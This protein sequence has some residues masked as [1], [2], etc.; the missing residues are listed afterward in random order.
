MRKNIPLYFT[1]CN[2]V[3]Q[4]SQPK[5]DWAKHVTDYSAFDFG[6]FVT[7][8]TEAFFLLVV[9]NNFDHW[10]GLYMHRKEIKEIKTMYGKGADHD[11]HMK[12]FHQEKN[13]AESLYTSGHKTRR[14]AG[15]TDAGVIWYNDLYTAVAADRTASNNEAF[16][17]H[18]VQYFM[19][20][21]QSIQTVKNH[22][23]ESNKKLPAK[24]KMRFRGQGA[25][26]ALK[27]IQ[28]PSSPAPM[29]NTDT[30]LLQPPE[31]QK[32]AA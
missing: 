25:R 2:T 23:D 13:I 31:Q 10:N 5:K 26:K 11:K 6:E 29:D 18:I 1:L 7:E 22:D 24:M 16:N 12:E 4:K 20:M 19:S 27:V 32:A 17:K 14:N 15:W 21:K 30:S 8:S 9:E 3:L 28:S